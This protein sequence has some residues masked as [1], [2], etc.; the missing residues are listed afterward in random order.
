MTSTERTSSGPVLAHGGRLSAFRPARTALLCAVAAWL[1][2]ACS[3]APAPVPKIATNNASTRFLYVVNC[4][5]RVDKLDS[6]T[7]KLVESFLLS[8]R[9]GSPPAVA[10]APD[11]KM[12]GCLAQR[13]VADSKGENVSLV[14]PKSA[15]LDSDGLQEFQALTFVLPEWRLTATL[16]AGKMPEAPRLELDASGRVHVLNDENWTPVTMLDLSKY[17]RQDAATGGLMLAS[18]GN[19]VLL[20]L[21]SAKSDKLAF[22]LADTT[23]LTVTRLENLPVTT[24]GHAHL[25]PGGGYVLV[26]ATESPQTDAKTTGALKLYDAA[27][28]RVGEWAD[29]SIRNMAFVALTPTGDA[30]Y[31]SDSGYRFIALGRPFGTAAVTKP[32]PDL[33]EPGLVYAAK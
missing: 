11:R 32:M 28:N 21:L 17:K 6:S 2:N 15:R 14:A 20:S 30:V 13:V 9:S 31:R 25:A 12:D 19:S 26:E 10:A 16:P 22:A 24:A 33:A 4:D 23:A 18:S 27:G 3:P 8:E 29:E 1:V 5:A 7:R